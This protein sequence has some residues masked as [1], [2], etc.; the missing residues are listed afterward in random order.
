MTVINYINASLEIWGCVMS[1]VVALCMVLSK[2]SMQH[3]DRVYLACLS[4]NA[5]VLLFDVLALFFRG[6]LGA[7]FWW[8][9]RI[10]NYLSLSF[11]AGLL[12]SFSCYLTEFL[13]IRGQVSR[14]PLRVIL[15]VNVLY[16]L[17]IVLTQFY[18]I[19]Y[20]IDAQNMYRRA[21]FFWM[22][23]MTGIVVL[24][25]NSFLLIRHRRCLQGRE[26]LVFWSYIF[27]PTAAMCVQIFVYGLALLNLANTLCILVIFLFLQAEQ[28]RLFAERENQLAQSRI[29]IL[30]SGIIKVQ[31]PNT[32]E[33][34]KM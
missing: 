34:G 12:I 19:V 6:N 16:L 20:F 8:G 18:P 17:L 25:I 28:G 13:G 22:S 23:Q 1:G 30:W 10:S 2:R 15:V 27:L 5:G 32:R 11:Y 29:A 14:R 33:R 9:V 7:F 4:C 21:D 31:S 24:L 26:A 3:S